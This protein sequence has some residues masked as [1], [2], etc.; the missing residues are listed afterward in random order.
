MQP[1]SVTSRL[2][3][4]LLVYSPSVLADEHSTCG[5][6]LTWLRPLYTYSAT[7][8]PEAVKPRLAP[9]PDTQWYFAPSSTCLVQP[10]S[11]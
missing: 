4:S 7:P 10:E 3:V 2:S 6:A 8:L 9:G 11:E 5:L 1:L